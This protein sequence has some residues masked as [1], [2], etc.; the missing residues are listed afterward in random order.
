MTTLLID[1]GANIDEKNKKGLTALN[2][3]KDDYFTNEMVTLLEKSIRNRDA[4]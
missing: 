3:A 1:A 4:H 2:L